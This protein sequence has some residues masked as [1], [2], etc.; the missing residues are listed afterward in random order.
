[1]DTKYFREKAT[2][3]LR[4]ADGLSLSNPGRF[5][6]MDLAE[7]FRNRA[8]ELE[9]QAATAALSR[10]QPIQQQEQPKTANQVKK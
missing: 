7:D 8:K 9:A 1:M 10:P 6:L 5:Q 3:C 2:L 4:V